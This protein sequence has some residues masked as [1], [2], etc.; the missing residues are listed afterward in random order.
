M[1][2]QISA[3][4]SLGELRPNLNAQPEPASGSFSDT[5]ELVNT[6][7]KSS[8]MLLPAL[9]EAS[10]PG[11]SAKAVSVGI[12][13]YLASVGIIVVATIGIFFGIGFFLLP[14]STA[15]IIAGDTAA[16]QGHATDSHLPYLLSKT[17]PTSSVPGPR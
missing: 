10:P 6:L 4:S 15:A 1:S 16:E 17:S 13:L 7:G 3:S 5:V 2:G 8:G 14:R 11:R 12:L 9:V